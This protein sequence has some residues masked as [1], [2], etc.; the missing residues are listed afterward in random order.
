MT[1]KQAKW[2]IRIIIFSMVIAAI[3][4]LVRGYR[5]NHYVPPLYNEGGLTMNAR[6][7]GDYLQI[8]RQGK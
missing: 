6:M 1:E 8:Y 7:E 4:W 3:L 2:L 5:Q